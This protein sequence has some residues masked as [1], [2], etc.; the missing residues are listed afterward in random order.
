M[1]CKVCGNRTYN[2]SGGDGFLPNCKD[3]C[4]TCKQWREWWQVTSSNIVA[5]QGHDF[6]VISSTAWRTSI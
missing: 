3:W 5:L 2:P 1:K 6:N 4:F